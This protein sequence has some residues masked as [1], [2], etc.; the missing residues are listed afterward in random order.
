[1]SLDLVRH[2]IRLLHWKPFLITSAVV[3]IACALAGIG[4]ELDMPG[5]FLVARGSVFVIAVSL[6]FLV[7]DPASSATA[8]SPTPLRARRA[9]RLMIASLPW[10]FTIWMVPALV[11]RNLQTSPDNPFPSVRLATEALALAA[12]ACL[13][14]S[15]IGR[16]VEQPG[17]RASSL[18]IILGI[19]VALIPPPA[20]PWMILFDPQYTG[21]S[22]A[23]WWVLIALVSVALV[24]VSWDAR[25]TT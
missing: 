13:V 12:I 10:A 15:T 4:D 24:V 3:M 23:S 19:A 8:V 2:T 18:L 25:T 22:V 11:A 7:D 17:A 14:S 9:H 6:A 21:M 20:Q 5:R 16:R 1:M